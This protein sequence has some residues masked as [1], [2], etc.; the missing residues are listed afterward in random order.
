M[1]VKNRIVSVVLIAFAAFY[2]AASW[3]LEAWAKHAPGPALVPRIL[4]LV[5]GVLAILI[6]MEAKPAA[7]TQEEVES[8]S[9]REPFIIFLLVLTYVFVIPKLGF[10][11][12]NLLLIIG[13]RR[14]VEPGSWWTDLAG[15][16]GTTVVIQVIFVYIL[17][18]QF[19][20]LP[21]WWEE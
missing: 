4:A 12:S 16:I 2:A 18:L 3:N 7:E 13:L 1:W 21:V 8:Y 17:A 10:P 5:L 11:L 9:K 14:M 19:P 6:W 15:A 20:T